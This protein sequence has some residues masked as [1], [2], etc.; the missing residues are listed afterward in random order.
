VPLFQSSSEFKLLKELSEI[1]EK[2]TFN[3]LLS[4]S[5]KFKSFRKF[6]Y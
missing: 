3:P 5:F 4:L 2:L 1:E 6:L